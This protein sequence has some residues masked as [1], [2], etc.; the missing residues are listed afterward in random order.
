MNQQKSFIDIVNHYI[1]SDTVTLPVFSA[2]ASR[3]Q[4]ELAKKN[5][6]YALLKELSLLTNLFQA[7]F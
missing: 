3:V 4:Q 1:Q 2:A 5:R 6:I 7:R